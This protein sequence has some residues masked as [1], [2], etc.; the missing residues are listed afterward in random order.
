MA[1]CPWYNK[2]IC[3]SPRTINE[4]QSPS[5]VP[6]SL[7]YCL[8]DNY[9]Q[10]PYYYEEKSSGEESFLKSLGLDIEKGF[11]LP[12]HVIPCDTRSDCPF[13]KV[14]RQDEYCVARCLAT[15]R[16]ITR[17]KVQKCVE[18]WADCPFYKMALEVYKA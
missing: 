10:C 12:I 17:S 7:G 14:I 13:F 11:Y 5:P 2:G 8:T 18:N 15:E 4:Y 3:Y 1:K 9:R 16:F 6:T